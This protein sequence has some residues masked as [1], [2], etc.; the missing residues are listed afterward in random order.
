MNGFEARTSIQKELASCA[1]KPLAEAAI[2]LP[3]SLGYKSTERIALAPNTADTLVANFARDKRFNAQN[4]FLADWNS[5]DFVFLLMD[6]ELR[7]AA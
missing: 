2:A 4:A 5:V 7:S 1:T 6:D 3:E